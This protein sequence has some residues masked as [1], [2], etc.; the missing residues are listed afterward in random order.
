MGSLRYWMIL[1]IV[2]GIWLVVS[3]FV[4]GFGEITGMTM[5]DMV[6]GAIMVI[7]GLAVA[8]R[9]AQSWARRWD[10]QNFFRE[11]PFRAKPVPLCLSSARIGKA[12]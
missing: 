3:P 8:H 12:L 10:P 5:N 9:G 1:Q 2:L 6:L 7:L 11:D 4:L